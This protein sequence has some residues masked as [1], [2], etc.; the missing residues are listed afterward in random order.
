MEELYSFIGLEG[1]AHK[2]AF[3][4]HLVSYKEGAFLFETYEDRD[5]SVGEA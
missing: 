1:F 5:T 2:T 3:L 4:E